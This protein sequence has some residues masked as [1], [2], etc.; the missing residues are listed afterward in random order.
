MELVI[1][2]PSIQ[3]TDS[4]TDGN[5]TNLTGF[6]ATVQTLILVVRVREDLD[7]ANIVRD[8]FLKAIL[9]LAVVWWGYVPVAT[10]CVRHVG[11]DDQARPWSNAVRLCKAELLESAA[12]HPSKHAR[13]KSGRINEDMMI[14]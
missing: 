2:E 12:V 4:A 1:S 3:L 9:G 14:K 11:C 10:S 13:G 7:I 6:E 8:L 5:H